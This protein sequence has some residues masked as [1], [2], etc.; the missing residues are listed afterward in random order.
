MARGGL[1][2]VELCRA[3]ACWGVSTR[4]VGT[5]PGVCW[6]L[7]KL[8]QCLHLQR[9]RHRKPA[10]IIKHSSRLA[11]RGNQDGE[12]AGHTRNGQYAVGAQSDNNIM[13]RQSRIRDRQHLTTPKGTGHE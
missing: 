2:G 4:D 12:E 8:L 10:T 9:R 6:T 13:A 1:V 5:M 3:V 7:R 11:D